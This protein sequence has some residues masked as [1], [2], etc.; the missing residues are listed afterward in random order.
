MSAF[1]PVLPFAGGSSNFLTDL[2]GGYPYG[3]FVVWLYPILITYGIF[4][5]EIKISGLFLN[6]AFQNFFC[7][8]DSPPY[9][10]L[11]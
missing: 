10:K 7:H 2:T 1:G 8:F 11:T 3:Q 5:D 4:V 6:T 9:F